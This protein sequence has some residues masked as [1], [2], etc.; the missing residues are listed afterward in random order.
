MQTLHFY[1]ISSEETGQQHGTICQRYASASVRVPERRIQEG[2]PS[3]QGL[4]DVHHRR[5]R[6]HGLLHPQ[7]GVL[8]CRQCTA[9]NIHVG[10]RLKRS[11]FSVITWYW[12]SKS[13]I[14]PLCGRMR[15]TKCWR[16]TFGTD[17]WVDDRTTAYHW[18]CKWHLFMQY[19]TQPFFFWTC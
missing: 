5:H 16:H 1:V 9:L 10:L 12:V 4:E 17:R 13:A 8:L 11:W 2:C 7:C 6:P 14:F 15:R 19:N 18:D 3:G